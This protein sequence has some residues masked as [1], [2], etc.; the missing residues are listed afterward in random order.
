MSFS[1]FSVTSASFI[2][3]F[4]EGVANVGVAGSL[5]TASAP[6]VPIVR[7]PSKSSETTADVS[8]SLRQD[9]W[10]SWWCDFTKQSWL[11]E[12]KLCFV[13]EYWLSSVRQAQGFP[14][15]GVPK[16]ITKLW[17]LYKDSYTHDRVKHIYFLLLL[18]LNLGNSNTEC[19][20]EQKGLLSDSEMW[21]RGLENDISS[22][23]HLY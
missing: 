3:M 14:E 16:E 12:L 2:G 9:V 10:L 17:K 22:M 4:S 23:F 11:M 8:S 20:R 19:G 5:I 1:S 13:W 21:I 18:S 6:S 7:K 15:I